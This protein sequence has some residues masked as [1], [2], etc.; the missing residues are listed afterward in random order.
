MNARGYINHPLKTSQFLNKSEKMMKDTMATMTSSKILLFFIMK[1]VL[2]RIPHGISCHITN[3]D[4]RND[5]QTQ[6]AMAKDGPFTPPAAMPRNRS[7]LPASYAKLL[8]PHIAM[9]S[10]ADKSLKYNEIQ[11]NF[12]ISILL[13]L[14]ELRI[15]V[16]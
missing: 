16:N 6:S 11:S 4:S 12:S 15:T 8:P 7:T 14:F 13:I 3:Y 10:F 5:V 9:L 1:S 2:G